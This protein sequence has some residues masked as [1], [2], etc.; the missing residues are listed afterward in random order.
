MKS[1]RARVKASICSHSM[2]AITMLMASSLGQA[3]PDA[4]PVPVSEPGILLLLGVG[5]VV[6]FI[7]RR[8]HK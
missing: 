6:M 7:A 4:N 1:L 5:L 2:A 3:T 8:R